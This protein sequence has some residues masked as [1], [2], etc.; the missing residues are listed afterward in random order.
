M[1]KI[2]TYCLINIIFLTYSC[3][4]NLIEWFSYEDG[5]SLAKKNN[6]HMMVYFTADSCSSCEKLEKSIFSEDEFSE[7]LTNDFVPIMINLHETDSIYYDSNKIDINSFR[8]LCKVPLAP[9][10]AIFNS[11]EEWLESFHGLKNVEEAKIILDFYRFKVYEE[12]K[13]FDY[14]YFRYFNKLLMQDTTNAETQYLVGYFYYHAVEKFDVAEKY[15]LK[16]IELDSTFA[17]AY[18][19]IYKIQTMQEG[20]E[21][22]S[23]E[24][25]IQKAKE[26]GFTDFDSIISKSYELANKYGPPVW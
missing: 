1:K 17:E 7:V 9:T 23:I 13:L 11:N 3:S 21:S 14:L 16:V 10:W 25:W 5:A 6:K 12:T 8:K 20:I 18:A 2:I 15:F 19:A 4:E 24:K 26:H 22:Q